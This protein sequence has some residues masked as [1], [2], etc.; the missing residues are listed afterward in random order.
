MARALLDEYARIRPEV[1]SLR[2]AAALLGVHHSTLSRAITRGRESG[3]PEAILPTP[4]PRAEKP[5]GD[6]VHR[7][8]QEVVDDYS[9][10]RE[11]VD[12]VR[13][14]AERMGMTFAALDKALYRARLQGLRAA[15]PPPGQLERAMVARNL[16][17]L[18]SGRAGPL[19]R[20][21]AA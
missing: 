12:S 10:I 4:R 17:R 20:D 15:L 18:L 11:D 9:M 7:P 8:L 2:Q 21:A 1:H 19:R 16:P 5:Q 13:Q 6:R 3:H 14:A